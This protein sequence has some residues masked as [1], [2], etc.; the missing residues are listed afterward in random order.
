[1]NCTSLRNF[2]SWSICLFFWLLL[3]KGQKI[4]ISLFELFFFWTVSLAF[5]LFKVLSTDLDLL[6]RWQNNRLFID[7]WR[8]RLLSRHICISLRRRI[9]GNADR[10]LIYCPTFTASY[11]GT[12]SQLIAN[13]RM[14]IAAY[15]DIVDRFALIHIIANTTDENMTVSS[16]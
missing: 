10:D 9:I 15:E 3:I 8:L 1:M 16:Y 6:R 11:H 7:L 14:A 5:L 4:R 13:L 2:V 12:Y